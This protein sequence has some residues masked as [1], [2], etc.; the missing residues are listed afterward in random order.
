MTNR[1]SVLPLIA[2][3]FMYKITL[4]FEGSSYTWDKFS[5]NSLALAF[6]YGLEMFL[7]TFFSSYSRTYMFLVSRDL[8][9]DFGL[10]SIISKLGY[11]L[12]IAGK[13]R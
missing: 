7:R 2:V 1:V 13:N 10:S 3:F 9:V 8:E 5:N 11:E 6:S 12:L 4:L